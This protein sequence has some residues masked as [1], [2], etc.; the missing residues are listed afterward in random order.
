[1]IRWLLS[2][3]PVALLSAYSLPVTAGM[4]TTSASA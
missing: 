4:P 3:L 2:A 1:V